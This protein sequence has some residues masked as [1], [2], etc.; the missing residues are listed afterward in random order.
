MNR[1]QFLRRVMAET[2]VHSVGEAERIARSVLL[3]LSD[4]LPGDEAS[5]M[6]SQLPREI[7]GYLREHLSHA[8]PMQRMDMAAF[9]GRIQVELALD[10][11]REAEQVSQGVFAVLKEAVSPG[12]MEDVAAELTPELREALTR[13]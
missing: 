9:A 11:P 5:D 3:A 2:G 7:K 12:E 8:G 6:A 1:E 13:S 4:D 10:T